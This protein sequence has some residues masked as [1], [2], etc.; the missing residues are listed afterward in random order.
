[1]DAPSSRRF[2]GL[3]AKLRRKFQRNPLIRRSAAPVTRGKPT[4]SVGESLTMGNFA[5]IVP[6]H[7]RRECLVLYLKMRCHDSQGLVQLPWH[8]RFDPCRLRELLVLEPPSRL[9]A[10]IG[11]PRHRHSRSTKLAD[12]HE[13]VRN[14]QTWI[15]EQGAVSVRALSRHPVATDRASLVGSVL[16][17]LVCPRFCVS[18]WVALTLPESARSEGSLPVRPWRP[19]RG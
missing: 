16:G 11:L 17:L 1:M 13:H 18:E 15:L 10:P 7:Q 9:E 12:I 4:D 14:R 5:E 6:Q 8:S 3:I 2:Q 19:H